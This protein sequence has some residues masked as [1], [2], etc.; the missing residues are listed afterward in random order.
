MRF[1]NVT[2]LRQILY[3]NHVRCAVATFPKRLFLEAAVLASQNL[4]GILDLGEV[5]GVVTLEEVVIKL[6]F[7]FLIMISRE[8]ISVTLKM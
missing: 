8:V 2:T 4:P 5:V 3:L 1:C 6:V 7:Y